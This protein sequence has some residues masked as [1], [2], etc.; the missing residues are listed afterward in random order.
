M[1]TQVGEKNKAIPVRT[2]E[3]RMETLQWVWEKWSH[4]ARPSAFLNWWVPAMWNPDPTEGS[5]NF[6]RATLGLGLPLLRDWTELIPCYSCFMRPAGLIQNCFTLFP[7]KTN[8]HNNKNFV[9]FF[10]FTVTNLANLF[11]LLYRKY[12]PQ[13]LYLMYTGF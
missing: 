4:Q 11:Y 13:I 1:N 2:A 12:S 10:F 7:L 9:T 3:V 5:R 8:Q 6:A